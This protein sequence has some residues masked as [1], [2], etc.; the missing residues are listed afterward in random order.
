MDTRRSTTVALIGVLCVALALRLF[1]LGRGEISDDEAFSWRIIHYPVAEM[2]DRLKGDANPPLY[3]L[4]LR[5][6][7]PLV[8]ESLTG[9]RSLSAVFGCLTLVGVYGFVRR[10]LLDF[11]DRSKMENERAAWAGVLAAALV[12][13]NPWQVAFSR[14][15]R[16]YALGTCLAAFS[17]WLLLCALSR[18][19]IGWW[20]AYAFTATA[21]AYTHY[22]AVFTLA[23]HALLVCGATASAFARNRADGLRM[24]RGAGLAAIVFLGCY[25]PW[26]STLRTQTQSVHEGFWIPSLD[27][28]ALNALLFSFLSGFHDSDETAAWGA[29][30]AGLLGLL[31]LARFRGW[32][33]VV[34]L[35]LV[36]CPWLGGVGVSL[37]SGRPILV[38]RYLLFAHLFYVAALAVL[39]VGANSRAVRLGLTVLFL[40]D[41]AAATG[42][43]W[44][45]E[46]SQGRKMEELIATLTEQCSNDPFVL[47]GD[48]G[49]ANQLLY[50]LAQHKERARV[51]ILAPPTTGGGHQVHA[52]SIPQEDWIAPAAMQRLPERLFWT[53]GSSPVPLLPS[54]A[55]GR[56]LSSQLFANCGTVHVYLTR[57]ER[58]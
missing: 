42:M 2:L 43:E 32:P 34:L 46:R 47:V 21:F 11:C 54:P 13:V 24:V 28:A 52:A 51:R 12:A 58:R 23:A 15:A 35:L 17:S 41:F 7:T 6:W 44:E 4:A 38:D 55:H 56:S 25:A 50:H 22:Y 10:L 37:L 45:L 3:Y 40:A 48:A 36:A 18:S 26:L 16:A 39:A 49:T 29:M 33:G 20:L 14:I 5:S 53:I 1:D 19:R 27:A 8:G 31:V 30:A 57:W 9:L